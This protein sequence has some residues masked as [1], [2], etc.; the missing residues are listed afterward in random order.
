[1]I[2]D[3]ELNDALCLKNARYIDVRSSAEYLDA[4]IPGAVNIPL[5]D[6]SER[7]EIGTLYKQE[8]PQAARKRGLELIGPG[9]AELVARIEEE[10][11]QGDVVLYCWRGGERS[12]SVAQLLNIMH[13]SGY[14]L[15]GGFREYRRHVVQRLAELPTGKVAVIHGLT[16]TGKTEIIK[17]LRQKGLPAVDLEELA[18]HRGSVFGSVGLGEQ[19]SQKEFDNRLLIELDWAEK[20]GYVIVESESRK[21]GRLF[22]P[23]RLFDGMKNGLHVQIYDTIYGRI[24]RLQKEYVDNQRIQESELLTSVKGLERYIGKKKVSQL[25]EL[26][27]NKQFDEAIGT[28]LVDYYDPLYG[29]KDEPDE[30]FD[31]NVDGNDSEQAAEVLTE[32]LKDI[33]KE[34]FRV[35]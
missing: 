27:R 3:I 14:R 25:E 12:K 16:G 15:V 31:L 20:F 29:Y 9:L 35:E 17:H 10:A 21:I 24:G 5:L 19:P 18:N 8:G 28:L 4:A 22:L 1:M 2:R 13:V 32:R 23:E 30:K 34:G 7:Q 33:F 26:I 11:T 6:N